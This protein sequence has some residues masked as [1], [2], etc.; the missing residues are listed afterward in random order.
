MKNSLLE[1]IKHRTTVS[2]C[3]D[4]RKRVPSFIFE[5][6]LE[7]QSLHMKGKGN[8]ILCHLYSL[9]RTCSRPMLE[10][11]TVAPRPLTCVLRLVVPNLSL[12]HI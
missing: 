5:S 4:I 8:I 3:T 1:G 6:D 12:I 7:L 11:R 2:V 9:K 10:V